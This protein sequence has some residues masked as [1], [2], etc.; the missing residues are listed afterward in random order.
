MSQGLGVT[1]SESPASPTA[2]HP[3]D[4]RPIFWILAG[5]NGSGK[6]SLYDE[7]T[8]I[9]AFGRSVWIINPDLLSRRIETIEGR[10]PASANL[11]AVIRIEAWLEASI[12]VHQTVG[13]ETVLS[14]GKYRRL[15][16]E[17]KRLNFEFRL[18]YV[19]LDSPDRNVER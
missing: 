15:V 14:T 4:E 11:E 6:S 17:A 7:N 18:I 9:Q 3:G 13:V 1:T 10:A 19:V 8:E 12:R 2:P 16:D 5:P